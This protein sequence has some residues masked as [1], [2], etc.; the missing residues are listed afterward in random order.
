MATVRRWG[1]CGRLVSALL[2]ALA[3]SLAATPAA[4]ARASTGHVRLVVRGGAE[5]Q[6]QA[7]LNAGSDPASNSV[8][9]Q[10]TFAACAGGPNTPDCISSALADINGARAAEGVGSMQLPADFAS[11]SVQLQVLVVTNLERVDRGLAPIRGLAADLNA[12]AD[13]AAAAD[14][15]PMISNFN[16]DELASNWAGGMSSPLVADFM[17]MYD[18]GPGSGNLDCQHA[19][20]QGC[21]GHRHNI[22]FHFDSPIV[23][24]V[25]YSANSS[26]GPSLTQL[27]IGGDTASRAGQADAVMAPSWA[28]LRHVASAGSAS[29]HASPTA[30]PAT[31]KAGPHRTTMSVRL[32][33]RR[34]R[35]G[36]RVTLSARLRARGA[37]MRGQIVT[38]CA[39]APGG[40]SLR[41]VARRRTHKGG[42]V[43]FHVRPSASTVYTLVFSGSARLRATSTRSVEIRVRR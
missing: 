29:S 6:F 9:S 21:W 25:G 39:R 42:R 32:A 34:V 20:D 40:R 1:L 30:Q 5:T 18:D 38:L 2:F 35:R 24:G 12:A 43:R 17:W 16:G 27:L 14:R 10:A 13:A 33:H 23:M 4:L 7:D 19:G 37:G 11:L 26:Y 15:D 8:A 41:V 28:A 36:Q 31:V 3:V 22:L